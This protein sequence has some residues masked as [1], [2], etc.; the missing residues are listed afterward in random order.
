MQLR[1]LHV[2]EASAK[3]SVE[4]FLGSFKSTQWHYYNLYDIFSYRRTVNEFIDI[5][6]TRNDKNFLNEII[7]DW[8]F[9]RYQ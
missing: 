5:D 3:L 1:V 4:H 2:S 9:R 8:G 7:N 6:N